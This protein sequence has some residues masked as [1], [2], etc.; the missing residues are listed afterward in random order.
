MD[1]CKYLLCVVTLTI[2][3][4]ATETFLAVVFVFVMNFITTFMFLASF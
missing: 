2:T 3:V 1:Y 4:T